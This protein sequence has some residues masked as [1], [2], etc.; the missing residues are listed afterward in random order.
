MNE[1]RVTAFHEA[2]HAIAAR[3]RGAQV[4]RVSI[5]PGFVTYQL[6]QVPQKLF[7][8]GQRIENPEPAPAAHEDGFIWLAGSWAQVRAEVPL[9]DAR[10]PELVAA[11]LEDNATDYAGYLA[12]QR[13][14]AAEGHWSN[15]LEQHWPY[16][17]RV[18]NA[19]HR[20]HF[21]KVRLNRESRIRQL[22]RRSTRF[23]T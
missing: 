23:P 19:L 8:N 18:A 9:S 5:D 4:L 22:K 7:R 17:I 6:P 1:A 12:A 14:P 21:E 10:F 3:L 2:G 13:D 11:T 16:I 20:E 15:Q